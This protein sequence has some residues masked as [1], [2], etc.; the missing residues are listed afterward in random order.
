MPQHLPPWLIPR[1]RKRPALQRMSPILR[2]C[3]VSTVCEAA[4][5]PNIGE[6][7]GVGTA[8]FL[9]L[10]ERCTRRCAYCAVEHGPAQPPDPEEPQR[11]AAAARELG[12]DYVV[13][14]SVT[15]D[16]LSDGGAAQFAE[17]VEQVRQAVADAR[18]EVLVPDFRGDREALGMVAAARPD[19]L[20]HN[21]ETVPRLYPELR[22]GADYAR[23]LGLL[24]AAAE[25]GMRTK[26]GAML[27]LGEEPDEVR[28]MIRDLAAA[29]VSML[30]LGQYLPPSGRHPPA[31]RYVTPQEFAALEKEAQQIGFAEVRAAPLVRSSYRAGDGAVRRPPSDVRGP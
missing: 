19:V 4:K 31:A 6:C 8:T 1:H 21:V 29:G 23:S 2:R 27:G 15:R 12:L 22:P 11:V 17:T 10:G 16:D 5:C 20:G 14:T 18:V 7:F 30:T 24:Q 28:G 3:G 13:V 25:A 26:S 9:I